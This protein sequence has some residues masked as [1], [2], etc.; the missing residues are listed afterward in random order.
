[1]ETSRRLLYY[2]G[3]L[4]ERRDSTVRPARGTAAETSKSVELETRIARL[5]S[6]TKG[7]QQELA[8][9]QRREVAIQAELDHLLARIKMVGGV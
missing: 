6:I 3:P 2:R 8:L 9:R 4:A 1:V 7:L 5:E